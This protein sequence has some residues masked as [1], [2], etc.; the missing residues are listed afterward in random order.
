MFKKSSM[1]T[2]PLAVAMTAALMFGA[3]AQAQTP[4]PTL[5]H[6]GD[7]AL[8]V[9]GAKAKT[10][11]ERDAANPRA[12]AMAQTAPP[13]LNQKGDEALPVTGARA[14]T[15]EERNE[16]KDRKMDAKA[17]KQGTKKHHRM[18]KKSDDASMAGSEKPDGS[19]K[20]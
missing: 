11:E 2:I 19:R 17:A 12:A 3:V 15:P 14:K 13:A 8:P 10:P 18:S 5:G 16:M 6:K 4:P 9:T 7:E 20:H 1:K